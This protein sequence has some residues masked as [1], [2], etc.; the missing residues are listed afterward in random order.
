MPR[1]AVVTP[2]YREPLEV[3]AQCHRSVLAQ[4]VDVDHILVADGFP[5]AE[6]NGWKARHV[7]LPSGHADTGNTP[8][9]IGG[10]LA[11]AEAY[12]FVAYLDADNWYLPGHLASLLELQARG[13][14][15]VCT[16]WRTFHHADGTPLAV[17]EP[18]EDALKHVDTNCF[19][20]GR[21]AFAA[22]GVWLRMPRQLATIGDR[23]FLAAMRHARYSIMSTRQR[24]VAYR[25]THEF[26]YRLANLPAPADA[27]P[28]GLVHPAEQWL[29]TKEG[30]DES[31][32]CLGFWPASY[33]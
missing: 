19:L 21:G 16:S 23:V 7:V 12:D 10:M 5:H 26:H 29:L 6:V 2:Y 31:V 15:E 28:M 32:R 3:L 13:G 1:I 30:V 17:A 11:G 20:I 4:G 9:G 22:L 14:V 24:T 33:M 18:A 8:R 25:T 27:K